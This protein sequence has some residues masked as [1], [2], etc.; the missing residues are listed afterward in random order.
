MEYTEQDRTNDFDFFVD[1]FHSLYEHYGHC[2]I[3]IRNGAVLGSYA[4]AADAVDHLSPVHPL[5]SYI[6]QECSDDVSAYTADIMRFHI[7][8]DAS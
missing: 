4:S 6:I 2:Y 8:V 5:G 3:A 1:H 7:T